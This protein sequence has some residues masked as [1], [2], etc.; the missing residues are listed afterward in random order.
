[1]I[2]MNNSVPERECI[3]WNTEQVLI[4]ETYFIIYIEKKNFEKVIYTQ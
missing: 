3:I 4:P 1:M 2:S